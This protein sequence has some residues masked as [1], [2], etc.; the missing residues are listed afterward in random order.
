MIKTMS[1]IKGGDMYCTALVEAGLFEEKINF[2]VALYG[3]LLWN[4]D[5]NLE[6]EY[7]LITLRRYVEFA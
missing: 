7:N 1:D 6:Y 3:E 5:A 2:A 4:P